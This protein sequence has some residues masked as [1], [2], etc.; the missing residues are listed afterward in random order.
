MRLVS[1]WTPMETLRA[2]L[3]ADEAVID[4]ER[5]GQRL[6]L[7]LPADLLAILTRERV[8]VDALARVAAEAHRVEALPLAEVSLGPVLPRPP[9]LLLLAGNYQSHLTEGGAPPVNKAEITPRF[10]LK[11][12]TAVIGTRQTIRIPPVSTAIDYEIEIAAVIGRRGR[13]IAEEDAIDHVFGYVLF[14]DISARHLTVVG[15]RKHRAGDE[16]FD[17]LVGK[18]CDT[19]AVVGPYLVTADE[20]PDVGSLEMALRV[21]GELRQHS[22][23]GEMIFTVPEAIAWIS[24]FLTLEPGDLICMGTPGG[25]GETTQTYLRPGDV[26]EA[27]VESLGVAINSV[28]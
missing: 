23:A 2:G 9:K 3:V 25:V 11:P 24:S 27:S 18:W 5:A 19:F 22:S 21:N 13:Q 26:V 8:G 4:L 28:V 17:W 10:F 14:N 20:V 16:F 7:A 6:G 12:G 1:Y 15:D